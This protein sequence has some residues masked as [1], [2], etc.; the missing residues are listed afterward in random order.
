[1][2]TPTTECRHC[3][4]RR[5]RWGWDHCEAAQMILCSYVHPIDVPCKLYEPKPRRSWRQIMTTP[6]TAYPHEA[7]RIANLESGETVLF[8]RRM[9]EQPKPNHVRLSADADKLGGWIFG[10]RIEG[11]VVAVRHHRQCVVKTAPHRPGDVLRVQEEWTYQLATTNIMYRANGDRIHALNEW[12]SAD[13]MPEWASRFT[14]TVIDSTPKQVCEI[15]CAEAITAG[16]PEHADCNIIDCDT[17]PCR[18][19]FHDWYTHTYPDGDWYEDYA[20]FTAAR[21]AVKHD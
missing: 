13:T 11:K 20:W 4:H 19:D 2:T 16:F 15:T 7:Q 17:R 14:L 9:D 8:V 5:R 6:I 1:M 3:K 10:P 18:D 21:K 12:K